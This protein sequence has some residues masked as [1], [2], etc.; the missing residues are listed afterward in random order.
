MHKVNQEAIKQL[1]ELE[2]EA[3]ISI[4]MP[5]HNLPTAEH[6]SE[7]TIRYKN[8][9]KTAKQELESKGYDNG[10]IGQMVQHLESIQE[11]THFWKQTTQG[12]ALFCSPA[13]IHYFHLPIE[14]E[15]Y[16][17]VGDAYDITPLL[18]VASMDSPYYVL[19]VAT[20]H[21][22]LLR[23]DMYGVEKV[24]IDLPVSP[25]LALGIDELHSNSRTDRVGGH[26]AGAKAHGQGDSKQAGQ[27]ERLKF[28]RIVDNILHT[29]KLIDRHVPLLLAGTDDEVSGY[30]E[31]SRYKPL[32]EGSLSGNYTEQPA[33]VLHER[34]WPIIVSEVCVPHQKRDID[35][36]SS[37]IGTG[38]VSLES[39]NITEAAKQGRAELLLLGMLAKTRDS[40]NESNA[41]ITKLVFSENYTTQTVSQLVRMV[42]EQGG[43]IIGML[44]SDMP[45]GAAQAA[46]Y[47]Y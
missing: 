9:I 15:P 25:E 26:G 22:V 44:K 6:I 42:V 20:K 7:D 33:H 32:L 14:C 16:V 39:D 46:M 38:R 23:G 12:I 37:L 10:I 28:F 45:K 36:I 43:R 40:S 3:T 30:K 21:P 35:K 11:D 17:S 41:V 27:E 47:R 13:G 34:S 24:P 19:A 18:V 29:S 1:L 5:T 31:I 8:L 4:Y 2:D